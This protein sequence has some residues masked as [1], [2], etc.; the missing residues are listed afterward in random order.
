MNT[1]LWIGQAIL[2]IAFI[3]SG[4]N[5]S[6]YSEKQLI[7]KGQ[8]GVVGLPAGL[9]RFI[10]ISE[11]AGVVGIIVPWWTGILPVLT[12]IAALGFA[13][14]MLLAAPIHYR[15]K[16]PKNVLVNL[17]LLTLALLVAWGRW[18]QL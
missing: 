1:I 3:F 16:E 8:T 15:L 7:L 13:V 2:A 9:I 10:G 17:T 14:I 6:V 12:P 18:S 4:V 5:K 11:I